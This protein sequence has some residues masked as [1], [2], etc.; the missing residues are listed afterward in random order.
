MKPLRLCAAFCAVAAF[1]I[2]G[3]VRAAENTI[4]KM[5][6][7]APDIYLA[8]EAPDVL[9]QSQVVT[10]M[11][12]LG[13]EVQIDGKLLGTNAVAPG[14]KKTEWAFIDLMPGHHVVS[15]KPKGAPD[16]YK[17]ESN[18]IADIVGLFDSKE[19]KEAKAAKN[20]PRP[21]IFTKEIMGLPGQV[22]ALT[23]SWHRYSTSRY[24][25]TVSYMVFLEENR[26]SGF[27]DTISACREA[28]KKQLAVMPLMSMS[29]NEADWGKKRTSIPVKN[30]SAQPDA[31]LTSMERVINNSYWKKEFSGDNIVIASAL[32]KPLHRGGIYLKY[33]GSAVDIYGDEVPEESMKQISARITKDLQFTDTKNAQR[34]TLDCPMEEWGV[35]CS[36]LAL[37]DSMTQAAVKN[38]VIEA[39]KLQNWV[40]EAQSENLVIGSITKGSTKTAL[41]VQFDDK[42]VDFYGT[43]KTKRWAE[44][45]KA[46]FLT[47]SK[48]SSKK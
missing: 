36:S 17:P 32:T 31:I 3:E 13:L 11:I 25:D 4:E 19:T 39:M 5:T 6:K 10:L 1:L 9:P 33:T 20:P 15:V 29:H 34:F 14:D 28:Y 22:Y 44:N 35:K 12:Q 40:I 45:V 46:R 38:R 41:Y 8:Y 48:Q 18:M 37:S 16:V 23:Y 43:P 2:V 30:K 7:K 21:N 42:V 27:S 24:T 26:D 47:L